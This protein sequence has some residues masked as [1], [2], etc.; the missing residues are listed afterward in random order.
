ME[1]GGIV[2]GQG[3]EPTNGIDKFSDEAM[4]EELL[5]LSGV[6]L[7]DPA[8]AGQSGTGPEKTETEAAG[9][10]QLFEVNGEKLTLEELQKGY[11]RQAD[12]T[13]KTQEV[14]GWRKELE[15]REQERLVEEFMG[16]NQKP[17]PAQDNRAALSPEDEAEMDPATRKA[18]EAAMEAKNAV[19]ALKSEALRRE[20]A[21]RAGS[22][23]QALDTFSARLMERGMTREAAE[24]KTAEIAAQTRAKNLPYNVDS[25][26]ILYNGTRDI[27][28]EA[29]AIAKQ[30]FEAYLAE[31]AKDAEAGLS[32]AGAFAP[33]TGQRKVNAAQLLREDPDA[34]DRMIADSLGDR[35]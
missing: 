21:E 11:M 34:L 6:T 28:A 4:A 24:D 19:E 35:P 7:P 29:E 17:V 13:K 31:K 1:D 23:M 15:R 8:E 27:E 3:A 18:Y 5:A 16:L 33:P 2:Q 14:A 32:G 30:K 22:M 10:P 9:E 12:Y 20:K 25:F 26:E